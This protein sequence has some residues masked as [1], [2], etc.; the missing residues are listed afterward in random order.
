MLIEFKSVTAAAHSPARQPV[1]GQTAGRA[2]ATLTARNRRTPGERLL[3]AL[4]ALAQG[5]ATVL[6]HSESSWASI[7]F[8]GT[9]HRVV[10]EFTGADALDAG[11][12]FIAF[13]PEHEF[14]I[15]G[16]LV[17]DAAVVEVDHVAAPPVLR[18]TCELLLLEEG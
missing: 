7:T 18:V 4:A 17:A 11:E 15:P 5:K 16:Q 8:A 9:R 13:L 12:C 2:R 10:L 14:A 1:L 3:E 6:T